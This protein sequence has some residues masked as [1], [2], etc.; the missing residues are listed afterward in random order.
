[1]IGRKLGLAALVLL[2][3]M[4]GRLPTK[5]FDMSKWMDRLALG[6]IVFVLTVV[7]LYLY[8]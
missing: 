5:V 1:M 2:Y 6:S 7:T 8:T 4:L 3:Y